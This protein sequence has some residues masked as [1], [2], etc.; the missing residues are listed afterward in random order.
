MIFNLS[1]NDFYSEMTKKN[2]GVYT[3]K[4]QEMLA[5]S[6]V[7]IFGLGGVG[8]MEAI[9]CARAGIGT[10][11]GVDPDTFEISNINRQMLAFCSTINESK[12]NATEKYLKD[13]NPYLKTSFQNI[14]VTEENV[15]ELIKGHDVVLEA[16]DDM[17]SRI[18]V[19][20]A[21]KK[22]GIPSI[23][24]SG[25]PPHRG[26]VSTFVPDGIDYE[27]ALNI[28][29][30]GKK[31][32]DPIVHEFVQNLKKQR[33]NYSVE[34]G[35]PKEWADDF[36]SGKVGWIITPIRASLLASFSCHE[37]I[38]LIIGKPPLALA[39]KGL[40]IDLDNLQ[41]PVSVQTPN[42]GYWEATHI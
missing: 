2:I 32:S 17:P 4:E 18:V 10:L 21:A 30:H 13:I 7:I 12:S 11:S 40:L 31:I 38:Q 42:K 14:K 6:K 1:E 8:G 37:V 27:T 36:C 5:K 34:K 35:A 29:T 19:H 39:P 16:L 23:S 9:L 41:N 33:A 20:R 26:F 28:P 15:D 22:Y 25:S 24:M 3:H